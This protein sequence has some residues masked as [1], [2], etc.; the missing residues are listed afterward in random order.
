MS[1]MSS[2]SDVESSISE[3]SMDSEHDVLNEEIDILGDGGVVKTISVKGHG[4]K[5]RKGAEVTVHYVGT[6]DDG[7]V[8]DSS[9][10]RDEPF[11]FKLGTGQVIRA[12]DTGV[13][14]MRRGEK[15]TLR[16]KPEYAYGER[17]APPKIPANATLTFEVELLDYSLEVDLMKDGGLFKEVT[18]DG[19]GYEQP[20]YEATCQIKWTA[21]LEDGTEFETK[22]AEVTI[23][24]GMVLVGIEKA[25]ESMKKGE[26]CSLRVFSPAYLQPLDPSDCV[27]AVPPTPPVTYALELLSFKKAQEPYELTDETDKIAVAE[28][29]KAE[30][31]ALF[32]AGKWLRAQ[33]K[34]NRALKFLDSCYKDKERASAA[35]IPCQLNL[36]ATQLRL[37]DNKVAIATCNKVLDAD[38]NNVKAHFR[39]GQALLALDELARALDDLTKA[40]SLD[41][42]NAAIAK[43][44]QKC[45]QRMKAQD[46]KDRAVFS[47]MFK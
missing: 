32:K 21:T 26:K 24:D 46:S 31:N 7:S 15:A 1:S 29:K 3:I 25:I 42:E 47:K 38:P 28:T 37:G 14:T 18:S 39:R 27:M 34:Y 12:W 2:D 40:L 19:S 30:G 33:Q 10:D 5:A 9:R 41:G 35:K 36:A 22:E 43:E 4:R 44:I 17:G 13:A 11:R 6:L 20:G 45:K 8:F 16:C 23:G